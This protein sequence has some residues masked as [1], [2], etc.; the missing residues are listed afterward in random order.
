MP[1]IRLLPDLLVSQIAAG[2]VVERPA[3]ALKELLE[4]A[5]DSGA[6]E[7]S[8][9]LADGGI[10]LIRVAD[11]GG[12]IA[13]GELA[14][15]LARHATSKISSLDDLESVASLGFRGEALAS[16]ASVSH[17]SLCSRAAGEKH[18]WK[19]EA[20]GGALSAP[21]PDGLSAG[22]TVEVRDLFFNTPARRKFLRTPATEYAHCEE[23]FKRTALSRPDLRLTLTHNG[24]A[25]WRLAP[26]SAIERV[27]AV[28]G[29][30]F[31]ETALAVEA[32]GGSLR[33][34]G[35]VAQ[36]AYSRAAR[37]AQYVFVNGRYVRD[38]LIAHAVREA[39]HDVLHH[40]RH[41]AYVLFLQ[42]DPR[43]VDVNVHPAKTEVRFRDSR[44]VHQF[45]FHALDKTLSATRA[46]S[47]AAAGS[48]PTA[49]SPLAQSRG[50]QFG[51]TLHAGEPVP[52]YARLFGE[53]GAHQA[54]PS[55][56]VAQPGVPDDGQ[57]LGHA[58]AQLSGVYILA[59][60]HAGLVV[61]DMHAAHERIVYEQL[62]CALD[63]DRIPTQNLL[64][65]ASMAAGPLEVAATEE[66]RELLGQLGFEL[67]VLA[68]NAI[69]VRAVP[70]MLAQA[71]AV[72]LA[73]DV[74][75]EVSEFGASRVLTE[76]RNEMLSTMACHAAVRA[77]RNL[78]IAEMNA[79]L[80][81]M[82][83]TERSGQCNHGRPTWF[84]ITMTELDRMFLRGR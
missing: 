8:V 52:F 15:A 16:I 27:F 60:N 25:Q 46:G 21:E 81:E 66:N 34:T 80:R 53:P 32:P 22:S 12:G 47:A 82:E 73:R 2:E 31:R 42:I 6:G 75:R 19:I 44:A 3:S 7:I 83:A 56:P 41:A 51:M 74:L 64:I 55:L 45:V 68:P 20:S 48:A 11:D 58:L 33:L 28:L 23:A 72:Q 78:A 14:L 39:Y 40:D 17:L 37:D 9:Q 35:A 69:A 24:R 18:A 71:D 84:Q 70:A 30:A 65:A 1:A 79:L 63:S 36:P 62:K 43:L 77:N 38:K 61:V 4:N 10:R 5:V 26:A 29:D 13:R 76:R 67:A 54:Q 50:T 49:P 57:P 59:Q